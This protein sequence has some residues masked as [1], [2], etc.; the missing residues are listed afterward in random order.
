MADFGEDLFDAFDENNDEVQQPE[1]VPEK[2]EDKAVSD[3]NRYCIF[4]F[5]F[6]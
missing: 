5:Q 1:V 6:S 4:E 3:N 2:D